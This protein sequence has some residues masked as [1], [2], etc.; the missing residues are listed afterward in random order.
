MM[1]WA[2]TPSATPETASEQARQGIPTVTRLSSDCRKGRQSGAEGWLGEYRREVACSLF[3]VE[4]G[5]AGGVLKSSSLACNDA[6]MAQWPSLR[7][8]LDAGEHGST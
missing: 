4:G 6:S 7:L 8:D 2:A 1:L 3:S 5:E